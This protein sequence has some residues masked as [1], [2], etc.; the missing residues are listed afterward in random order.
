MLVCANVM[1][2]P[3]SPQKLVQR[4]Y[5]REIINAV[6]NQETRE[7]MEYRQVMKNPKYRELYEKVYAKELFYLAQGIPGL[8]DGT[9]SIFFIDKN[10]VLSD[11]CKDVTYGKL[12]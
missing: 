11:R 6:L 12:L 2:L 3:M 10:N 1:Q 4:K 8:A 9:E 7:M 5:P